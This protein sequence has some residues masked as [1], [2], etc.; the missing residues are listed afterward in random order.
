MYDIVSLGELLID[1]IPHQD[2]TADA[3]SYEAKV[4]GAPVNVLSG[5]AKWGHSTAYISKVG[6][7]AFGAYLLKEL[8]AKGINADNVLIEK[9]APTTVA[10]VSLDENRDRTFDFIR[11]PGAEQLLTREEVQYSLIRDAKVFHFGSLSLTH[12][13]ARE[14]TFEAL[15]YAKENG[16]IIS[17]DPNY[18]PLL[19]ESAEEAKT[20]MVEGLKW[21]HIVKISDEE[22]EF[23]T[24]EKDILK[25]SEFL[26]KV[27]SIQL[28]F[29]TKG[30][31]GALVKCNE[32]SFEQRGFEVEPVD[33]T[34]AG[35]SFMAS[36][37]HQFL[38]KSKRIEELTESD[39][40]EM[41][42]FANR[43]AS[44]STTKKGGFGI[45]PVL[46]EVEV[47]VNVR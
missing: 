47:L 22:V 32:H 37:L 10:I 39:L 17:F 12:E 30:K 23:I 35:D 18:R 21:A 29:V 15:K 13:P 5:L 26:A 44:L 34:G 46:N 43:V 42:V 16:K 40:G 31:D 38:V 7:D 4:G 2:Y 33:T 25:A 3:P 36:V 41:L 9:T 8:K 11:N 24:G 27:Y 28:L 14:A 19:W 6:H 45:V 20:M 1:L